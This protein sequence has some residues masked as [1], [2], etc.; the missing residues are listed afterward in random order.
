MDKRAHGVFRQESFLIDF[1]GFVVSNWENFCLGCRRR[2]RRRAVLFFV[3]F[4]RSYTPSSAT[5]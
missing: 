3:F 2:Q 1:A 5:F 4:L